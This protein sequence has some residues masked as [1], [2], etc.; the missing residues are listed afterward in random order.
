MDRSPL[1]NL[2]TPSERMRPPV[3]VGQGAAKRRRLIQS[4]CLSTRR[5]IPSEPTPPDAEPETPAPAAPTP[6]AAKAFTVPP[7][8]RVAAERLRGTFCDKRRVFKEPPPPD[9]VEAVLKHYY[10]FDSLRPGQK[11]VIDRICQG[12]STLAVLPTGL[13]KSLCYQMPL[14][15]RLLACPEQV[16]FCLVITPLLSLLRDQIQHLPP[17][18]KGGSLSSMLSVAEKRREEARVKNGVARVLFVSPERAADSASF[19]AFLLSVRDALAF[20]CVDEAH[21]L[22]EWSHN[23]R[24]SYLRLRTSLVDAHGVSCLLCLTATAPRHTAA[25]ITRSLGL[26]RCDPRLATTSPEGVRT[27]GAIIRYDKP[28]RNLILSCEIVGA[29]GG[30]KYDNNREL[31]AAVARVLTTPPL[32]EGSVV[33]YVRTRDESEVVA[34]GLKARGVEA[35]SYNSESSARG[36]RQDQFILGKARVVVATIAFGMGI[37]KSNVRGV[38]HLMLPETVEAYVQQI[39]R[40]GRDGQDAYCHAILRPGDVAFA[41]SRAHTGFVSEADVETVVRAVIS[42]GV[43][44][45]VRESAVDLTELSHA[46]DCPDEVVESLLTILA[47]Q[48]PRYVTAVGQVPGTA[49]VC[50][51]EAKKAKAKGASL[52]AQVAAAS[53]QVDALRELVLQTARNGGQNAKGRW[54]S[55]KLDVR[56][57]ALSLGLDP[58]EV[59]ER[60]QNIANGDRDVRVSLGQP[61]LRFLLPAPAPP[62]EV[63]GMVRELYRRSKR[64]ASLAKDRAH[65]CWTLLST[66]LAGPSQPRLGTVESRQRSDALHDLLGRY[67]REAGE[68]PTSLFQELRKVPLPQTRHLR[69]EV[70]EELRAAIVKDTCFLS[71]GLR[72]ARVCH[73]LQSPS[74]FKIGQGHPMWGRYIDQDF[75]WLAAEAQRIVDEVRGRPL[76]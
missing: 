21:C 44:E 47:L 4:T 59:R 54:Q 74:L 76:R 24:S 72:V 66:H 55:N 22:S 64:L 5:P 7:S 10:G 69:A 63:A 36:T 2:Q 32:N 46:I 14:L 65:T 11:E 43:G 19:S 26:P 40:A 29:A 57:A 56:D 70:L 33:C 30:D 6:A 20:V 27:E 50:I 37:D 12:S 15:L 68:S 75:T 8:L 71:S 51:L 60:L 28:R 17:A 49:T 45:R 58:D 41:L 31:T 35:T 67:N 13:G 48:Q 62:D 1:A 34:S 53:G 25:D 18:L 38:V 16:A 61:R 9:A 42:S 3:G 23:F 39:G 52:E 73:A